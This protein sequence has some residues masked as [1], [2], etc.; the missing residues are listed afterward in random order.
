MLYRDWAAFTRYR[1]AQRRLPTLIQNYSVFVL[2][3]PIDL[4]DSAEA[5]EKQ[6][7]EYFDKMC[8]F[9]TIYS[10]NL[11]T[12]TKLKTFYRFPGK[13]VKAVVAWDAP[14]IRAKIVKW[15]EAVIKHEKAEAA[16]KSKVSVTSTC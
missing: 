12:H 13:V 14:K 8:V 4:T 11:V 10:H 1:V 2:D 15:N 5:A 3:C 16:H 6:V 7:F 9:L